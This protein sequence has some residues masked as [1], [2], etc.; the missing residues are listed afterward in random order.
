[1]AHIIPCEPSCS[2]V[3]ELF[4]ESL[5]I[6][7]FS[8]N[9]YPLESSQTCFFIWSVN[10]DGC[11][12]YCIIKNLKVA[13]GPKICLE[14]LSLYSVV[15]LII[16]FYI[17]IL[18]KIKKILKSKVNILNSPYN[19]LNFHARSIYVLLFVKEDLV[20]MKSD[21]FFNNEVNLL[22]FEIKIS[23]FVKFTFYGVPRKLYI[24]NSNS[25]WSQ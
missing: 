15:Y 25:I 14:I 17:F 10:L 16:T 20:F 3:P 6:L 1:M 11:M 5:A 21:A 18:C 22:I 7:W 13:A 12:L 9:T 4:G 24:L 2:L 19:F 23:I 8:R